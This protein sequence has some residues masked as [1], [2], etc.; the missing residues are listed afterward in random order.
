ML[1]IETRKGD[2]APAA[3]GR[4]VPLLLWEPN[5][6]SDAGSAW[7]GIAK[8]R[9]V[10]ICDRDKPRLGGALGPTPPTLSASRANAP[11]LGPASVA[12][13]RLALPAGI[14]GKCCARS[15]LLG[16]PGSR[17]AGASRETKGEPE[18]RRAEG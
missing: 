3:P 5:G 15:R 7:L 13:S 16:K 1:D 11:P 8:S 18:R 6:E 12:L 14:P 10:E 17:L 9:V 4:G 2:A